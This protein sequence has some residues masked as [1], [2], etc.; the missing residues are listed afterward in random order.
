MLICLVIIQIEGFSQ[1]YVTCQGSSLNNVFS[2]YFPSLP[3]YHI[4]NFREIMLG[5]KETKQIPDFFFN[6]VKEDY[7][8]TNNL[9]NLVLLQALY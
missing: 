1:P 7:D 8:L 9:K 6:Q 4:L 2:F 3:R 5:Q